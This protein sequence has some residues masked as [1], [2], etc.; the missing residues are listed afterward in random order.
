MSFIPPAYKI[1]WTY[2][3]ISL[4]TCPSFFIS[5]PDQAFLFPS[6]CYLCLLS[7]TPITSSL[8]LT[9]PFVPPSSLSP[10]AALHFVPFISLHLPMSLCPHRPPHR[11][12][13][14]RSLTWPCVACSSVI[15]LCCVFVCGCLFAF[16]VHVVSYISSAFSLPVQCCKMFL[17]VYF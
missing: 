9:F 12:L 11:C 4:P 15:V 7:L 13:L 3:F 1:F 2:S 14:P 5:S 16:Y 10:F 6:H 17:W 8:S